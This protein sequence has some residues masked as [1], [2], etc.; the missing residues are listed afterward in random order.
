MEPR[1]KLAAF[2]FVTALLNSG[3]VFY[4]RKADDFERPTCRVYQDPLTLD[5]GGIENFDCGNNKIG[6]CMATYAAIG[7]ASFVASGSAVVAGNSLFWLGNRGVCSFK[8]YAR[9]HGKKR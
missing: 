7:P 9:R 6:A 8:A 4:P 5:V 1:L 2:A 3:C